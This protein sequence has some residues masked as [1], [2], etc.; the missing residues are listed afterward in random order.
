VSSKAQTGAYAREPSTTRA[1][2]SKVN[3][4]QRKVR[5]VLEEKRLHPAAC[6]LL[7]PA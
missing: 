3:S 1:V 6:S 5:R 4:G 7:A 2:L